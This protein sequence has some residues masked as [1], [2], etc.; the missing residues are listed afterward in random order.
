MH[1]DQVINVAIIQN[2]IAFLPMGTKFFYSCQCSR[3]PDLL[4]IFLIAA[5]K[6]LILPK[7]CKLRGKIAFQSPPTGTAMITTTMN[8]KARYF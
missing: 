6:I 1:M 3:V 4:K 8:W 7:F 5:Q 2:K